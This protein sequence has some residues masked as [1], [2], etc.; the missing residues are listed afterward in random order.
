MRVISVY[1]HRYSNAEPIFVGRLV[2]DEG[3][4]HFE[5]DTNFLTLGCVCAN[6]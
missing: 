2:H 1:Y 4:S 3:L 5:Y 6:L